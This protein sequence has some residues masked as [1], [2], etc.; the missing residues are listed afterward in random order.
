MILLADDNPVVREATSRLLRLMG[1]EVD[2]V[3]DGVAA[4]EAAGRRAY[5]IILLDIQMP[6]MGGV[7]A[8]A[9]ICRQSGGRKAPARIVVISAEADGLEFDPESGIESMIT[10]PIRASDLRQ[11]LRIS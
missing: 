11:L 1:C 10:K 7:E 4:I 5:D 3:C 8:A 6:V 2:C 9:I